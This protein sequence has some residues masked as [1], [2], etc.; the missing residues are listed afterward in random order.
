MQKTV[1]LHTNH[2]PHAEADDAP[3]GQLQ[4]V[5]RFESSDPGRQES[6]IGSFDGFDGLYAVGWARDEA[7]VEI[8]VS[9]D[10]LANNR[11]V[12]S[13]RAELLRGDLLDAGVGEGTH[14]FKVALPVELCD[15][16]EYEICVRAGAKAVELH[17]GARIFQRASTLLGHIDGV[18]GACVVGW[19]RNL[20][21]PDKA[22]PV[23]LLIDGESI[24]TGF[25]SQASADGLRFSLRIPPPL[26]DGR[27][28]VISVQVMEPF[29]L[30]GVTALVVPANSTPVD[31]LRRYSGSIANAALIEGA[32]ARYEA[33]RRQIQ[34]LAAEA[35]D[36]S[37]EERISRLRQVAVAHEQVLL[38]FDN[39][40]KSFASLSAL[41][42]PQTQDPLVSVVIPVHNKALV[43]YNCLASLLLAANRA[44][45]EVIVVDDGSSDETLTLPDLVDGVEYLRHEKAQGFIRSCN[46]G[47]KGARGVYVVML[48]N[49]TEVA[50]GWIDELIYVFEHF[51]AV[52]MAGAKLLY[53]N[54]Q[55]QEAGGIVWN[56]GDPWNYGRE[57]N[58]LEPRF[59]YTRQVD[60]LSGACVMLRKTLWDELG[61]FDERF[62]PAYFEDA[63]LAFR[64]R[65][66]G[67]KT[68]YTPFSQIIHF[69]GISSGKS[70]TSG[71]KRY[72]E[73]NRPK[74]KARWSRSF[75]NNGAIG[76]DIDLNKDRNIRFRALVIDFTTPQPDR[77]AGSYAAVQ[78]IRLLQSLGFKVTFVPDNLAYLA[79][80]TEFLQRMGVECL[81]APFIVSIQ[82]ILETRG[83][84]FDLVYLTR[85]SIAERHIDAIRRFAP[86][87]K[88]IFNNADLHFLR[89]LRTAIASKNKD[90]MNHALK[91]RD[92]ELALMRKVDLVLSYND[93]EHAVIVSHNLDS[94]RIARCPWS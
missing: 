37:A 88:V 4:Q 13:G 6:L 9:V 45:F 65:E 29:F 77:D 15:G 1:R 43:T 78:E 80:P 19:V 39:P 52:G 21:E 25:A 63:D 83:G 27:P 28:H 30:V 51:N 34:F 60:Y 93:A 57:G 44:S 84:E 5:A 91:T 61:G 11:W 22:T 72:Q 23:E 59:N 89:E 41:K 62:V 92:D 79:S 18:D 87:A 50:C 3:T 35:S 68:V 66:R 86:Q 17:P 32:P 58:S 48:N 54:G 75:K 67:L 71:T 56:N 10:V 82:E 73:I 64:V 8:P 14:G 47:A 33:L 53:P 2:V 94:T 31:A 76:R 38:G 85:Y 16:A 70:V 46:D 24:S 26:M 74:F 90:G 40:A 42:F 55:L 81:Y 12:A 69:E 36:L 7:A 20:L 49:D